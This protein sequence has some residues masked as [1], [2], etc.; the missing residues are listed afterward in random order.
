MQY[1]RFESFLYMTMG[2]N[3]NKLI[4]ESKKFEHRYKIFSLFGLLPLH[5]FIHRN[6]PNLG[7]NSSLTHAIILQLSKSM[8]NIF[9]I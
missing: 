8:S 9:M 1:T 3:P 7:V 6:L 5:T 4:F 2:I